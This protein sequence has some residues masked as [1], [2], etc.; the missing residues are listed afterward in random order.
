[1]SSPNNSQIDKNPRPGLLAFLQPAAIVDGS[2]LTIGGKE[3][4]AWCSNISVVYDPMFGNCASFNGSDSKIEVPSVP[5]P[6]NF[7]FAVWV[8]MDAT[9]STGFGTILEF[10]NDAP[11]FGFKDRVPLLFAGATGEKIL[12][13]EWTHVV[14]TQDAKESKLYINNVCVASGERV[15]TNGLGF[16][17][18]QNQYDDYFKGL[19]LSVY[20]FDRAL[21]AEEIQLL[22]A[23]PLSDILEGP[24]PPITPLPRPPGLPSPQSGLLTVLQPAEI[25]DGSMLTIGDKQYQASC[26]NITVVSDPVFGRCA[27]FNGVNSKIQVAFVPCPE[28]FTFTAWIKMDET[29]TMGYGAILEFGNDSPY[30]GFKGQI[31]MLVPGAAGTQSLDTFWNHLV[32]TQ[33]AKE[34]KLYINSVCVAF[35]DFLAPTSGRGFGMGQNQYDDFFKGLIASIHVFDRALS[36]VEI[37]RLYAN[38]LADLPNRSS[39]PAPPHDK[40]HHKHHHHHNHRHHRHHH[41]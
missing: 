23:D 6:A 38:P 10:G 35:S 24:P 37:Q 36:A 30:F 20:L 26:S 28:Q 39:A 7:T 22:Y 33:D 34:S 41:R 14:V 19:M 16:G 4:P 9:I 17:I 3:Y 1:M 13:S 29:M 18:G 32:I 11:F 25:V 2:V 12:D 5:C 31:P 15:K 21:N 8:K 40:H 27:S